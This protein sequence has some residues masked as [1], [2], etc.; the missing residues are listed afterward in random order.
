[1]VRGLPF[2]VRGCGIGS[3]QSLFSACQFASGLIV[4][5]LTRN[6]MH[7]VLSAFALMGV[8]AVVMA[9]IAFARSVIGTR[10]RR[11]LP[12]DDGRAHAGAHIV[13]LDAVPVGATDSRVQ[14]IQGDLTNPAVLCAAIGDGVDLVYH[15]AAIV[16][17]AA[18]ADYAL[19]RRVNID[20]TLSLFRRLRDTGRRPRVVYASSIAVF[21]E[22]PPPLVDDRTEPRPTMT[23][24]AQTRMIEIAL[25]QFSA[26]LA[27]RRVAAAA[28][29][30][31]QTRGAG[32]RAGV[33]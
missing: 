22:P 31:R 17:G 18:E 16:G 28:S 32:R 3:F 7:S 25:A 26:R 20:A 11:T 13:L 24:A 30:R 9:A 21:G 6:V 10:A 19:A 5:F 29:D 27:R 12:R 15:L 4:P 1:M 23:Y 33:P 14:A 8:I 2:A